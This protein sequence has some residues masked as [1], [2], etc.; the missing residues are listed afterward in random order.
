MLYHKS[1]ASVTALPVA[2][3][4]EDM[5]HCQV[6]VEIAGVNKSLKKLSDA[7]SSH[8]KYLL[9]IIYVHEK[10]GVC[11]E[12]FKEFEN[13]HDY[14][15]HND[16]CTRMDKLEELLSLQGMPGSLGDKCWDLEQALQRELNAGKNHEELSA[17]L[18]NVRSEIYLI[19]DRV[20]R[21]ERQIWEVWKEREDDRGSFPPPRVSSWLQT[22]CSSK[23]YET[24]EE[25]YKRHKKMG[26]KPPFAEAAERWYLQDKKNTE[27]R[28][29]LQNSTATT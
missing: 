6:D 7:I 23:R 17:F 26:L 24:F 3:I 10:E 5:V 19:E 25:E 16:S 4:A 15:P 28:R 11:P 21:R 27:Q 1:M 8:V 22:G 12:P 2:A 18:K 9:Y 20:E 14:Y 13:D 29:L